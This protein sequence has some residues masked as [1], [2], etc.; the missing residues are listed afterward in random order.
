VV[1]YPSRKRF[2]LAEAGNESAENPLVKAIQQMIDRRQLSRRPGEPPYYPQVRLLVRAEYVRTFHRIYPG[3]EKLA[4][5]KLR[6]NLDP[7]DDVAA[8]V[9]GAN[10]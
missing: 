8:I 4:A 10:P 2:T 3:L 9:T 1:L 6:Q 5:P 7:E